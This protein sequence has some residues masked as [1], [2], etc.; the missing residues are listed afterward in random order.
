MELHQSDLKFT[1]VD[2]TVVSAMLL[3]STL[4]GVYYTFFNRQ[5]TFEDYML[6][7]K[8]MGVF[9]VSMSLVASFISGITLLGLPT[10]IYL[11]GTQY[12]VINFSVL[13][14]L[15]LC[16][17]FYLPVFYKLQLNSVFEYL[18]L[19][20]DHRVR[21]LGISM[22][23]FCL[24]IYLPA[25][26]YVPSLAFSQVTGVPVY[27]VTP[28]ISTICIF[29]TTFGGLKA[30]LW[31]DTLQ[32]VFTL[33]AMIFVL[34]TGCMRLGGIREVWNINKEGHRLELFNMD[35][36]PF[37]RNTFWTTF[38]GYLFMHLTNLAVNPAAIQRYLSVPTLRQA[39]WTVFYTG[40][41]FYIIMNLTTFLGLVL[42][43]RY[44]GCDPVAAGVIKTHSQLVLM[45]VTEIGKSY[46]GLA[47]L[48]LSG[49]LSAALSS[50]SSW[51][52]SVG[53]SMYKDFME[54]FYPNVHHSEAKQSR[55]IK[56]IILILGITSVLLVFV[57]ERLGQILQLSVTIMGVEY[58][59]MISLF[60]LG[61]F[62]PRVNTKGAIAGA[63]VSLI[64]SCWIIFSA[65]YY[66]MIGKLQF[67]GKITSLDQC[68]DSNDKHFKSNV[69]LL[70]NYTG[71]GSPVV[72][73]NSVLQIYQLSYNYYIVVG[74]LIGIVVGLGVSMC[75]KP[76]DSAKLNPD[77][78]ST[79]VHMFLPRKHQQLQ[80]HRGEYML[81]PTS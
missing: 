36:D 4:V 55:I 57:V 14:V 51:L 3:L 52:N 24:I 13:G 78:F 59:P 79:Y 23:S 66:I 54:V 60:T 26:L 62:F 20:F 50:V 19:R 53:G 48:F 8:T 40:V 46:P 76:P 34:M 31:T 28:I 30:V 6:G 77:L 75:T 1:W 27:V 41:G 45:Y 47:G 42:Y 43:A 64:T 71:V 69:S 80:L 74:T 5:N 25:V 68:S 32:N 29:Y 39:R 35:P 12:S 38:F 63:I 22:Y 72:A 9:P 44:H 61:I 81:T 33:A 17:T 18:E 56:A 21:I 65:Q 37:A 11:Y 7:G 67:P 2:Y 16:I 58:G 49:V 70:F 15:I 73:D 10:E